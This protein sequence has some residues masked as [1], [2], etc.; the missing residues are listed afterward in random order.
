MLPAFSFLPGG[1]TQEVAARPTG[2]G[3][4]PVLAGGTPRQLGLPLGMKK[5]GRK[6]PGQLVKS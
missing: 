2:P 6:R 1:N 3:R 5:P 4:A